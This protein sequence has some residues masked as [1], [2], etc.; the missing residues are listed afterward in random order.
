MA[1]AL[2]L[3]AMD[4]QLVRDSSE[5]AA[6]VTLSEAEARHTER[7]ERLER[8]NPR[9]HRLMSSRIMGAV[10]RCGREQAL[11]PDLVVALIVVE[12]SARP[13]A[14]SPKGA[15]GLM[16]VMP[17]MYEQLGMPGNVAHI[18]SNIEA[19][20]TILADNIR[21]L[22]EE[23]GISAYYWGSRIGGDGYLKR[24][25]TVLRDLEQPAHRETRGRG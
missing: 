25:L 20:C 18:E 17:H 21:R 12:S 24:V 1:A 15:I 16:Q 23:D 2:W 4:A 11:D 7:L 19:G 6:Q 22:G 8:A 9:L 10:D 3:V 14:L 5:P 13:W